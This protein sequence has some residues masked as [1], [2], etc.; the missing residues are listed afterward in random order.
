M[1]RRRRRSE[2]RSRYFIRDEAATRG[3]DTRHLVDGGDVLEE[4]EIAAYFPAI[5]L[6]GD[7]PDFLFCL[8]GE[9]VMAVEAKND[10]AMLD[11]AIAQAIGYAELIRAGGQHAVDVVAGA[12]GEPESGVLVEIRFFDGAGWVPLESHGFPLTTLPSAQ[13]VELALEAR[14]GTT[15]VTVPASSEFIDAAIELSTILRTAKIEAPLRPK[16]IGAVVVA[17]Y[18]GEV[19][20][21]PDASLASINGL[22]EIAIGRSQ[23]LPATTKDQLIDALRLSTA[24]FDRLAPSIRRVV[25]ILRRLNVRSVLQTDTDFLGLFYEAFLRYGYDNNA[26]GIVFTPRHVTRFCVELL[27]PT[28]RDRSIDIAS[29]TGGFLASAFDAMIGT[30]ASPKARAKVKESIAGFETNPTVWALSVLNMFFRGDGKS[31]LHLASCFAPESR[32]EVA[33]RFSKGFLNPPFSQDDE[34]ESDFL[35]V[36]MDALEP[37]GELAAIVYA[38]VFADD[39]HREWRKQFLAKH[40]LLAMI[41]MPDE[42][43]YPTAAPTTVMV[44]RAHRPQ[45]PDKPVMM[46]RVWNDGFVKLKSRRVEI[47]GSQ[48]PEIIAQYEANEDER[49]L[50]SPLATQVFASSILDGSEWSP[51]QWL[52]QPAPAPAEIND[53]TDA[54]FRAIFQAVAQYPELA[55]QALDDFADPWRSLPPLP[56]GRR[57]HVNEFFEVKIGGSVGERNY[58]DGSTPYVSSGDA[59]NSIVRLVEAA[60]AERFSDGALTVTAFGTASIQ[61]WPFVGRGNGG[62]AVRVLIP[63][64]SM[65]ANEL[66]WF[67]TQINLQHWRFFYARMSIK[68]RLAQLMIE[69]PGQRIPDSEPT[70][71]ERLREFRDTLNTLARVG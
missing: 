41:S 51:Q 6:G 23:D 34:P 7:K 44:A 9:P 33:S 22:V 71:A 4:N 58:R 35:D 17:M 59:R 45:V 31:N 46:A 37:D 48:L 63:R 66:G 55:D 3:W 26:L 62:S 53:A 69:S 40:T 11:T 43:F 67:A 60:D 12:A 25:S 19:D 36:A 56:L 28:A 8:A 49:T 20:L 70:L 14:N 30:A 2:T 39:Y 64:F 1:A 68:S 27:K 10:S 50:D 18:Q 42:L 52:P 13:E 54:T 47:P 32:S 29:G 38:G 24:D 57:G 61:P 5:G 15:V 16:V 65:S 21:D